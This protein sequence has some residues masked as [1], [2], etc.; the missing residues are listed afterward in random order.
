MRHSFFSVEYVIPKYGWHA[1]PKCLT[2]NEFNQG[3]VK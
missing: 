3:D 1:I 2:T